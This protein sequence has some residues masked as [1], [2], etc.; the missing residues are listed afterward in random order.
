MERSPRD[1]YFTWTAILVLIISSC[2]PQIKATGLKLSASPEMLM[3]QGGISITR[4]LRSL[5]YLRELNF[6]SLA[7]LLQSHEYPGLRDSYRNVPVEGR[8]RATAL[9]DV[10]I[11]HAQFQAVLLPMELVI[12]SWDLM[13][14]L[15]PYLDN[16]RP[17]YIYL[18]A[19]HKTTPWTAQHYRFLLQRLVDNPQ[20]MGTPE[21]GTAAYRYLGDPAWYLSESIDSYRAIRAGS[22]HKLLHASLAA[23]FNGHARQSLETYAKQVARKGLLRSRDQIILDLYTCK[24]NS[25][26]PILRLARKILGPLTPTL[27]AYWHSRLLL[28]LLACR[29]YPLL[30]LRKDLVAFLKKNDPNNVSPAYLRLIIQGTNW[31]QLQVGPTDGIPQAHLR[32]LRE[33]SEFMGFP[34]W[35]DFLDRIYWWR[36][37]H[38]RT[39]PLVD[40]P[41][42]IVNLQDLLALI[43]PMDFYPVS[44]HL[45]R[46]ILVGPHKCKTVGCLAKKAIHMLADKGNVLQ[47]ARGGQRYELKLGSTCK[48]EQHTLA[49]LLVVNML[50]SGTFHLAL[51]VESLRWLYLSPLTIS[52]FFLQ[53]ASSG[54]RGFIPYALISP[55]MFPSATTEKINL[56]LSTCTLVIT[57]F[58]GLIMSFIR[59]P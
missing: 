18:K 37:F 9:V 33:S 5:D 45:P 15:A 47:R 56:P 48:F 29:A 23:P 34:Y 30:N 25:L 13:C 51:T 58:V 11:L 50:H 46:P 1:L 27:S 39:S 42:R 53:I 31:Y 7:S 26:A 2:L 41:E 36:R 52:S 32:H 12:S 4:F 44:P 28:V 20:L 59:E 6:W 21:T 16:Y 38:A 14:A 22:A 55:R 35:G 54:I 49:W 40:W 19:N 17:Q 43:S 10:A 57:F 8:E 24:V 3:A